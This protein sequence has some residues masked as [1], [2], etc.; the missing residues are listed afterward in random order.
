MATNK[1]GYSLLEI[2]LAIAIISMIAGGA[3]KAYEAY[4][5]SIDFR[6]VDDLQT[7]SKA[8]QLFM[9]ANDNVAPCFDPSLQEGSD[10]T[11]VSGSDICLNSGYDYIQGNGTDETDTTLDEDNIY[12]EVFTPN[13]ILVPNYIDKIP[14][15]ARPG[16]PYIYTKGVPNTAQGASAFAYSATLAGSQATKK[17]KDNVS[18]VNILGLGSKSGNQDNITA[19]PKT[20]VNFKGTGT[21][22]APVDAT[23]NN[24]DQG[25]KYYEIDTIWDSADAQGL[26][27][28]D[29]DWNDETKACDLYSEGQNIFSG[30]FTAAQSGTDESVSIQVN[31]K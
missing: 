3:V 29:I 6:T 11:D 4:K 28:K 13:N 21:E 19:C 16:Q 1:K 24:D 2:V 18:L 31:A 30:N 23:K 12:G 9:V 14:S 27:N 20:Y 7:L 26:L 10:A 17:L 8:T 25:F 22:I 5:N 15:P